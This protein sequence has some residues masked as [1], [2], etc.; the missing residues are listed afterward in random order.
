MAAYVEQLDLQVQGLLTQENLGPVLNLLNSVEKSPK[1]TRNGSLEVNLVS[2]LIFIV[3]FGNSLFK[4][5]LNLHRSM[6]IL[7]IVVAKDDCWN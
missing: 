3:L 4:L 1:W 2:Q 6:I 5:S 7:N